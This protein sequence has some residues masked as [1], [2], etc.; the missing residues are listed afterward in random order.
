M[1]VNSEREG[2]LLDAGTVAL[3]EIRRGDPGRRR[4]EMDKQIRRANVQ[5]NAVGLGG[6]LYPPA[7]SPKV[8]V[9]VSAHC[10][11]HSIFLVLFLSLD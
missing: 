11:S 5:G 8:W 7:P 6:A 9:C 4:M 3:R 10:A 2:K 1:A